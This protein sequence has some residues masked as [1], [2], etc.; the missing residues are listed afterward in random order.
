[1]RMRH[2]VEGRALPGAHASSLLCLPAL[3]TFNSVKLR[4]LAKE[5]MEV[6]AGYR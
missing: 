4:H 6:I 5:A 3:T 1:M 2:I